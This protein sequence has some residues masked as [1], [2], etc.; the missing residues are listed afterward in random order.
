[1]TMRPDGRLEIVDVA[2]VGEDKILVHDE[3]RDDPSLAFAL[4]R[5][6]SS[7]TMPT[8]FGIFRAVQR[9]V[10]GDA[11]E[12]QLRRAAEVQ[13]PGDLERLLFS[14]DTWTVGR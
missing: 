7:P 3:T 1:M 13:G 10:Y 5:L 9:P 12:D 11:M 14:G 4:S 8:P 2:Q 6:A